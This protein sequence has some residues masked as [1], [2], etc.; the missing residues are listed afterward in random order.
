MSV[1]CAERRGAPV[2]RR[3]RQLGGD[4]RD[5]ALADVLGVHALS[6]APHRH[7]QVHFRLEER[8][9]IGGGFEGTSVISALELD[10]CPVSL[11]PGT[12]ISLSL[13]PHV[14]H[15]PPERVFFLTTHTQ[16][17]LGVCRQVA[18]SGRVVYFPCDLDRLCALPRNNPDHRRLIANAVRWALGGPSS[19]EVAGPGVVDVHLCRQDARS[20]PST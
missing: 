8:D 16:T 20:S 6:P 1:G 2:R 18:G 4:L 7:K 5:F 15:M 11:A 12:R 17:P 3:R 9:A 13:V 14:P 19:V 10:L